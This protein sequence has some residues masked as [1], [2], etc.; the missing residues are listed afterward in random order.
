MFC[1][2]QYKEDETDWVCCD[3]ELLDFSNRTSYAAAYP[4]LCPSMR[5]TNFG[6]KI[7][8]SSKCPKHFP[9]LPFFKKCPKTLKTHKDLQE[10]T[11]SMAFSLRFI[12]AKFFISVSFP[13]CNISSVLAFFSFFISLL[14]Y[15]LQN[16]IT[17]K[18]TQ[19]GDKT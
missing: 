1:P 7:Q 16:K 15:Y 9:F 12:K 10:L 13:I 11:S 3:I 8:F 19:N 6:S 4:F 14:N 5:A 18:C 2:P 17:H